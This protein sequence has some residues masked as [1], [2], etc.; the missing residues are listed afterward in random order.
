MKVLHL[1]A[2]ELSGGAARGAYWLHRAEVDLGID[3]TLL[4]NGRDDLGDTSVV[5]LGSTR[6]KRALAAVGAEV[7]RLPT[8]LYPNREKRIFNTGFYGLDFTRHPAYKSADLLHL[9][10]INGLV[11]MRTLK[12]VR[13]PIV[14]TMRDMWPMTGGCHYAMGGECDRY[15]VGCGKCPQ[16][17]S[18]MVMDLSRF[19][20]ANKIAALPMSMQLIGISHWLSDRA[21]ESRVFS[22]NPVETISNNIDTRLFFP[23]EPCVARSILGIPRGRRIVLIGAQWVSDFYK[24]FDLFAQAMQRIDTQEVHLVLFGNV[25]H[26]DVKELGV[27]YSDLGFLSDTVSLRL[28]YAAAD[29]FVAPSRLEAF[30]KT[31]AEAMACGTPVVCFDATGTSDIVEHG[32]TGYKAKPFVSADLARGIAWVLSRTDEQHQEMR[33]KARARAVALFDSRVI[34]EQYRDLYERMLGEP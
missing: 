27:A 25:R 8:Y 7:G 21:R 24:G 23:V 5:A 2:G 3:S 13:K 14:W 30:G 11:A 16:L 18:G 34:A 31:L 29:V 26:R 28:A 12:K 20:V 32:V 17:G 19:V 4:T 9:H 1:V 10:W 22:G 33:E 6:A 15:R